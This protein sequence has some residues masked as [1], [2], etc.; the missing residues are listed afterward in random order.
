[1]RPRVGVIS[2]FDAWAQGEHP[3]RTPLTDAGLEYVPIRLGSVQADRLPDDVDAV[4]WR[5]SENLYP[6]CRPLIEALSE[7]YRLINPGRCIELC[8]DKWATYR[9]LRSV[10][11]PTV[12]TRLLV[13]DNLIPALGTPR[14]VVKP[15]FGAGGR[16]IR[17]VTPG[18]MFTADEA[19]LAQP[20]I[21]SDPRTHVRVLVCDGEA[22]AA[23]HRIPATRVAGALP[24][25]NLDS[26]GRSAPADLAPV[27]EL[28]VAAANAVD[29]F[30]VG[31]DLV[32][33]AGGYEVLEI[34]SSPGLEG[35]NLHARA[36]VYAVAAEALGRRL[37][38]LSGQRR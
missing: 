15:C 13:P 27:A 3:F 24:I 5:V 26:G 38:A 14:T 25:N 31:V 32:P 9:H 17:A 4:L 16:G 36:D 11:L 28:A 23:I 37:R 34:N 20:E 7:R 2:R 18:S 29:G 19:Y 12:P 22:I 21:T 33:A 8:S 1:M 35:A 10:G 30:L 6:P